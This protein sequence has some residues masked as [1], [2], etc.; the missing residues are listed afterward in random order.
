MQVSSRLA[1]ARLH[2]EPRDFFEGTCNP[3]PL[4]NEQI[5]RQGQE[6]PVTANEAE[7]KRLMLA[8]LD[9]PSLASVPYAAVIWLI[10]RMAPTD[11]TWPFC[12]GEVHA[13]AKH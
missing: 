10:R 3:S 6:P 13:L 11:L 4:A 8:S 9:G 5:E 7:L 12:D 2:G 1:S